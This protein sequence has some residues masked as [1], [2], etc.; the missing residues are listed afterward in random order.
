MQA[1]G[2]SGHRPLSFHSVAKPNTPTQAFA[3][4]PLHEV[5]PNWVRART[6]PRQFPLRPPPRAQR[7]CG[8]PGPCLQRSHDHITSSSNVLAPIRLGPKLLGW[9]LSRQAR[10]SG[11]RS[12]ISVPRPSAID[13]SLPTT[14]L[15]YL[16]SGEVESLSAFGSRDRLQVG[17]GSRCLRR[18]RRPEWSEQVEG[19]LIEIAKVDILLAA[20][21]DGAST[22][23]A[24]PSRR[25][26]FRSAAVGR[27]V[28][29]W[30]TGISD[31]AHAA[32]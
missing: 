30:R 5:E 20:V 6:S 22:T 15:V 14:A 4:A 9:S 10:P 24:G 25:S 7:R 3:D 1:C 19:M 2:A 21:V 18:C 32:G 17:R 23:G 28:T 29:T 11:R 12:T 16:A 26:F 27:R 8:S 13:L 31:S